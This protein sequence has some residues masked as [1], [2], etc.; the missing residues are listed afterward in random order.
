MKVQVSVVTL[1]EQLEA[2]VERL[3]LGLGWKQGEGSE[4]MSRAD[5]VA[6][7]GRWAEPWRRTGEPRS[8]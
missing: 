2:R 7:S 1:A 4:S 6:T 8:R 5:C 3:S